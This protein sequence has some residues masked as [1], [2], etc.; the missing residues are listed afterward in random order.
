MKRARCLGGYPVTIFMRDQTSTNAELAE[1]PY[2]IL[3]Q[4][5]ITVPH[6]SGGGWWPSAHA[7]R[8]RIHDQSRNCTDKGLLHRT[9]TG[10]R[11]RLQ[12]GREFTFVRSWASTPL[13]VGV[14]TGRRR[15]FMPGRLLVGDTTPTDQV[16]MVGTIVLE[17]CRRRHRT[18]RGRAHSSR[19][20]S[21]QVKGGIRLDRLVLDEGGRGAQFKLHTQPTAGGRRPDQGG[22]HR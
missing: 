6:C 1:A 21:R 12:S 15:C 10:P 8:D 3:S 18:A 11:P 22:T 14:G 2:Q 5:F 9:A 7:P 19:M 13:S 20:R 16:A 17:S 4:P